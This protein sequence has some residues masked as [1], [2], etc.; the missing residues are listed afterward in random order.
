MEPNLKYIHQLVR[1]RDWSGS[2]LARR[3]GVSRA[4][5]NRF[6]NGQRRGGNKVI[7]GLLRAFPGEKIESLFI[8][9][10]TE[11]IRNTYGI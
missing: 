11:P 4:K 6:L 7:G 5:A 3:M 10:Q 2:E 8:L 9:P 1:E